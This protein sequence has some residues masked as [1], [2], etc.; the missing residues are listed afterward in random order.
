[1]VDKKV[2]D[3]VNVASLLDIYGSLLTQ[4]Q[5]NAMNL[6]YNDDLSLSEISEDTGT[7]RQAVHDTVKK[8]EEQLYFFESKLKIQESNAKDAKLFCE[9]YN[10]FSQIS[11]VKSRFSDEEISMMSR[12]IE[13]CKERCNVI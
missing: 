1:M 5:Y 11:E 13:I 8:A 3:F 2:L 10:F 9:L 4:K 7:S 12:F 6:Y